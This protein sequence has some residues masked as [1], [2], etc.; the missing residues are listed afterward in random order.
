M[1]HGMIA[2]LYPRPS[3]LIL[4]MYFGNSSWGTSIHHLRSGYRHPMGM[5]ALETGYGMELLWKTG[6]VW[7]LGLITSE[8]EKEFVKCRY[9]VPLC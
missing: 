5:V 9:V 3:I 7:L 8:E 2:Q 1:K 4:A 6:K